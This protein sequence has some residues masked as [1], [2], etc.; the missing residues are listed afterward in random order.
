M[1]SIF[2][3]V[4]VTERLPEVGKYV[5]TIDSAG[6]HRV[7]KRI[8]EKAFKEGWCWTLREP[9]GKESPSNNLPIIH[10]LEEVDLSNDSLD[11]LYLKERDANTVNFKDA[12][13]QTRSLLRSGFDMGVSALAGN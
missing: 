12:S 4:S 8:N 10:W 9:D 3:K 6:E 1:D 11:K 7:Y 5:T 13:V 2:R